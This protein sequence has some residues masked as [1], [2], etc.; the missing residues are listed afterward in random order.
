ME[1]SK[2]QKIERYINITSLN[3]DIVEELIDY[4]YVGK[5]DPETGERPIE[6]NW[7]L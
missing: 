5:K 7:N 4:I 1:L 6:I 2:R 3:R